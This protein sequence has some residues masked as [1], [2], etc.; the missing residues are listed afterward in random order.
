MARTGRPREPVEPRFWSQVRKTE[1]CWLW[2]GAKI[3]PSTYGHMR[4]DGR[5]KSTHRVSWEL[6]H[7][8]IPKGL[9]VCHTCDV[10]A[11]VRP[12]HLF[13]GTNR[14]N[15]IDMVKKGRGLTERT[16][17]LTKDDVYEI[18]AKVAEGHTQ[19]SIAREYDLSISHVSEVVRGLSWKIA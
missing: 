17:R 13:L 9:C 8:P 19:A 5:W 3:G 6:H 2:T 16:Y 18:R 12:A 11:C 14:D 1:T 7:G 15:M 4:V 10:P